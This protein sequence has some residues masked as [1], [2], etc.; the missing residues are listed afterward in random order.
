MGENWYFL[1]SKPP[2]LK[3]DG[4]V[5]QSGVFGTY[6]GIDRVEG[7]RLSELFEPQRLR[8]QEDQLS[9]MD[10]A[11]ELFSK[12]FFTAQLSCVLALERSM[13]A[14]EKHAE[15]IRS[16]EKK[17]DEIEAMDKKSEE[18]KW[19]RSSP[20]SQAYSDLNRSMAHHFLND[21]GEPDRTKAPEP[22]VLHDLCDRLRLHEMAKHIPGLE[23]LRKSRKDWSFVCIGWDPNAVRALAR[24]VECEYRARMEED[25]ARAWKLDMN[26]HI[27]M[28]NCESAPDPTLSDVKQSRKNGPLGSSPLTSLR[29]P[30]HAI[31]TPPYFQGVMLLSLDQQLLD[32]HLEDISDEEDEE[33]EEDDQDEEDDEKT[34]EPSP[35]NKRKATYAAARDGRPLK[36]ERKECHAGLVHLRLRGRDLKDGKIIA[37]PGKGH[38]A[39]TDDEFTRFEG[40][41]AL[42]A[43]STEVTFEGFKI[44]EQPWKP[45]RYWE[46]FSHAAYA[47]EEEEEEALPVGSHDDE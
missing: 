20:A 14:D 17:L 24:R 9:T 18:E 8:R 33:T 15:E 28:H 44:E 42:P 41:V 29:L 46:D 26:K 23:T 13:R 11:L 12:A 4:F 21:L 39:F 47:R 22:M 45:V 30:A 37:Y 2:K 27:S 43:Y 38:L 3:R 16:W 32:T 36:K 25:E 10:E 5:L 6:S 40:S 35:S 1:R 31:N 7:G 19:T 34:E